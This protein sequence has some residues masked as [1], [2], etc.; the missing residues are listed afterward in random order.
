MND[1][2][3]LDEVYNRLCFIDD[4][5]KGMDNS[6][7]I[8]SVRSFIEQEWQKRDEQE[9]REQYNHNRP[10][11]EHIHYPENVPSFSKSWYM[12]SKEMERHRGLEIGEDGTVKSLD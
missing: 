2:Q 11:E 4:N 9:L 3:V 7:E 1:K 6:P 5:F 8:H 10:V 12:D